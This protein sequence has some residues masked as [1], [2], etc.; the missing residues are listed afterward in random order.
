MALDKGWVS[1]DH[2][3]EQWTEAIS[4]LLGSEKPREQAV[5]AELVTK[6]RIAD[7][8]EREVDLK[9]R[10]VALKEREAEDVRRIRLLKLLA[11]G[12]PGKLAEQAK[13]LGYA[14]S[15]G[16]EGQPGGV[17]G[18]EAG[19]AARHSDSTSAQHEAATRI[20]R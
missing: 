16:R 3:K 18:S 6:M 17:D 7:L 19:Q 10:E 2:V 4:A 11:S 8:K 14:P 13:Q 20:S 12:D 15:D 1:A 5:G 9:E